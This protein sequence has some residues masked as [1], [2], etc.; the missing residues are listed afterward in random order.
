MNFNSTWLTDWI[1]EW[2]GSDA[3]VPIKVTGE[4]ILFSNPWIELE[5]HLFISQE[6]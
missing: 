4:C 2:M 6:N 5:N 1:I 3:D